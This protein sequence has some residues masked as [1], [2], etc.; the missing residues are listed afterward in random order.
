[1]GFVVPVVNNRGRPVHSTNL[2]PVSL[3]AKSATNFFLKKRAGPA[4]RRRMNRHPVATAAKKTKNA[5][6]KSRDICTDT[7]Q[8]SIFTFVGEVCW[9]TAGSSWFARHRQSICQASSYRRRRKTK[10]TGWTAHSNR[11]QCHFAYY[12]YLVQCLLL[13]SISIHGL[14]LVT[15][16]FHLLLCLGS[17]GVLRTSETKEGGKLLFYGHHVQ[18]VLTKTWPGVQRHRG[19]RRRHE[20]DPAGLLVD[21]RFWREGR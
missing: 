11:K 18:L 7:D 19:R 20:A 2:L 21:G 15:H 4:H 3:N 16:K 10:R 6:D 1:M 13:A 17:H 5:R 8:G 9:R 14:L 12:W